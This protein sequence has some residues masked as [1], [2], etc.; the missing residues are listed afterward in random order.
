[1]KSFIVERSNS[2]RL[3]QTQ[4]LKEKCRLHLGLDIWMEFENLIPKKQ[5]WI[6]GWEVPRY[7]HEKHTVGAHKDVE[8]F[9]VRT[10]GL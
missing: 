1:M 2:A 3:K 5:I 8:I 10:R 7:N 9:Q 6:N 4:N